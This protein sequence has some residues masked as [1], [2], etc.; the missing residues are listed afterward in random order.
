MRRLF[1]RS[2]AGRG[3][4][5]LFSQLAL[6]LGAVCLIGSGC[7]NSGPTRGANHRA[8]GTKLPRLEL[9]ALT[10]S[11][12]NI[13]LADLEGRVALINF[14]GTWCPPCVEEFPHIAALEQKFREND[15]VRVLAIASMPE[16]DPDLD[17]LRADIE[18]FLEARKSDLPTYADVGDRT[19]QAVER[20]A[21]WQGYPTTV[22]IDQQ[23]VIRGVWTNY[24]KG[25]EKEMEA[26]LDSLA[27]ETGE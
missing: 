7:G 25:I 5:A 27:V 15:G 21:G 19:R 17:E 6:L 14:W 23:G 18:T 4:W 12:E 1:A 16:V 13:A 20:T 22:I 10:G 11:A 2:F 26:M 8:V 9:Q 24:T 3:R